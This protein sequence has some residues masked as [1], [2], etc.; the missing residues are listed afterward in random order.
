MPRLTCL[1]V[2][3]IWVKHDE[4][5]HRTNLSFYCLNELSKENNHSFR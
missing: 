2:S 3:R 1:I 4:I 5:W